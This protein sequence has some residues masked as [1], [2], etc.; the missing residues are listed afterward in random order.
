MTP[1]SIQALLTSTLGKL[2]DRD[3]V[4][5]DCPY[6]RN[7]GD[8][9]LWQA[10]TDLLSTLHVRCRYASSIETFMPR[11]VPKDTIIVLSGGGNFGDLWTKH[12]EFRHK[13]LHLFPFHKI[14]QLP[15]SVCFENEENLKD[16]IEHFRK[17]QGDITICLR[18][19]ASFNII[20]K[21]Y[22]FLKA[23][24]LPD[25][26][27][28]CNIKKYCKKKR[29]AIT[30]GNKSL[31]LQR[32]DKERTELSIT[33]EFDCI[34]DW[35]CMQEE[36]LS[37]QRYK[38]IL[39]FLEQRKIKKGYQKI[40][41]DLYWKYILKDDILCSGIM[42]LMPYQSVVSTR[43]HGGI[44]AALL[45]KDVTIKDNTYGKCSGVYHLWMENWPNVKLT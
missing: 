4:L 42:F 18:D 17:H 7:V 41:C 14:V 34:S 5:L 24:L 37:F 1:A 20:K 12:Q 9:I 28:C 36:T 10:A 40:F 43:L 30:P 3:Y 38:K 25:L 39:N 35:P 26:A 6:Y 31:L 33:P 27:L 45:D 11:R 22:P 13:I 2:I 8:V 19:L 32:N 44:L 21:N 16:D 29:I 23:H 15:Q